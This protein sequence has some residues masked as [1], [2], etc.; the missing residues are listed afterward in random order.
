MGKRPMNAKEKLKLLKRRLG[1]TDN[2]HY[3][4]LLGRLIREKNLSI[5][6]REPSYSKPVH[7]RLREDL[8]RH[9]EDLQYSGGGGPKRPFT[10]IRTPMY[11]RPRRLNP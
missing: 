2:G 4:L 5:L 3:D 9:A 6:D 1:V 7:N 8:R 11:G 10:P